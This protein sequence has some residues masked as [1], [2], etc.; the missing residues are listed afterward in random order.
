MEPTI[1]KPSI[2]KGA[3]VYK[4]GAGA[5][6]GGGGGG[7]LPEEYQKL[8]YVYINGTGNPQISS[9]SWIY[10]FGMPS[11][12]FEDKI[13]VLNEIKVDTELDGDLELRVISRNQPGA[14]RSFLFRQIKNSYGIT[15]RFDV[16]LMGTYNGLDTTFQNSDASK[17]NGFYNTIS[18]ATETGLYVEMNGERRT[19]S[20]NKD[21]TAN[22]AIFVTSH[23]SAYS[24]TKLFYIKIGDKVN[25]IPCKRISDGQIGMYCTINNKFIYPDVSPTSWSGGIPI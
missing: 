2:Y 13:D 25:L 6:G 11:F 23:Y 19:G 22:L 20:G 15:Y 12:T 4:T 8:L 5:G 10:R 14:D 21:V 3:G 16:R 1:Y 18:G 7:D 9:N 17:T 24:G